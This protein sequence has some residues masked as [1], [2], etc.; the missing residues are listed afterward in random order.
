MEV[1]IAKEIGFCFGVRKAVEKLDD[2]IEKENEKI[3]VTGDLIHNKDVLK[4]YEGK[5]IEFNQDVSSYVDRG[6]VVIRAHGISDEEREKIRSNPNIMKVLDASCPYVLRLH[7]LTKKMVK[8]GYHVVI[9]GDANHPETRGYYLNVKDNATVIGSVEEIQ[10]IPK[11]KKIALFAQT[12]MSYQKFKEI[13][14]EL[15][16]KF[17]EVRVFMTICPP[18][19]ERQ[20]SVEEL[21]KNCDLM[22]VLGGYNSSNTKKLRDLCSKYTEAI[23]IENIHQLDLNILK[24]KRKVGIAAGTSTPDW[25]IE[26]AYNFLRNYQPD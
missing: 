15:L 19:Y 26:E 11:V 2:I 18:V 12:T 14:K 3:Y 4:K 25:I 7:Y 8:E 24:G 9:I 1:E 6:I 21:S 17:D 23:H 20:K 22:I 13:A 16:D 10:N 5:N